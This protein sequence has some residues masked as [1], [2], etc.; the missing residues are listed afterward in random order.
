MDWYQLLDADTAKW[1][2]L[3][4]FIVTFALILYRRFNIAYVALIAAGIIIL[5]GVVSPADA[6]FKGINWD[7]LAIYWGFAI[8]AFALRES[9]VPAWIANEVLVH[10]GKEKYAILSLCAIAM[11]LSCFIANP[12]VVL[13]LAPL[14]FTMAHKMK[15]DI[16]VYMIALAISSNVVT[17]VTMVADPPALIMAGETG[18]SFFEFYWFQNK[19]SL[20]TISIVGILA[21]LG[22]LYWQFRRLNKKI[23]I[24]RE[25]IQVTYGPMAL[26]V[27]SV[28]ALAFIPWDSLGAWNHRGLVGLVLGGLC[29]LFAPKLAVPWLKEFDWK[30]IFFLIGIFM[31]IFGVNSVGLL[32]DFASLLINTGL[33]SPTIYLAILVWVSVLLS[34]F[35]DNVPY[36]VIMLPVCAYLAQ[37]LGVSPFPFYFGMLIGT[38]MGG[39]LTPVGATANV[40][41]C[42]MLEKRGCA[43]DLRRYIKIAWPFT[44]AAVLA[45]HILL[46]I[47][48]L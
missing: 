3:A 7:V 23:E 41:A 20:G 46:Q 26:F 39:N 10:T 36:T 18:M 1:V 6:L 40:L 32:E 16:F 30:S 34:S 47:I 24:E 9:Q 13:I 43:I 37:S 5:L 17:T 21:A 33:S 4:V 15:G 25:K 12:E 35:I 44:A 29:L 48:W 2:T 45:S 28:A 38:G 11:V 22:V 42:G 8:L 31:L 14:A 27:I 19:L